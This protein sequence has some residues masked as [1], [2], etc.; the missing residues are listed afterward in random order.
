LQLSFYTKQLSF[1]LLVWIG[2]AFALTT[3]VLGIICMRNFGKGLKPFVQRGNVKA[4]MDIENNMNKAKAHESWQ[5]D[6]D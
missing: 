4:K 1:F 3:A 6:D 2:V 5:I